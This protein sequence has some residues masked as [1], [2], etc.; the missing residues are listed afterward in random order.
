MAGIKVTEFTDAVDSKY[1]QL[2][3]GM[4][5]KTDYKKRNEDK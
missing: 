2:P 3:D 5:D 1:L 4:K